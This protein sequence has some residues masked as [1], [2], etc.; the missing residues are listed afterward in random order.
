MVGDE[1]GTSYELGRQDAVR[2]LVCGSCGTQAG[3]SRTGKLVHTD[4]VPDGADEHAVEA[5]VT[6]EAW[7][8]AHDPLQQLR[9]VSLELVQH[10]SIVH[11]ASDCVFAQR[12][13]EAARTRR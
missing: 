7:D 12:V 4:W 3:T 8:S 9:I 2:D 10:H 1:A 5:L 11:P 6:R 13:A